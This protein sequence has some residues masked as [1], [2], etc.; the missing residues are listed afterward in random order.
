MKKTEMYRQG[1]VLVIATDKN[2][3]GENIP[4][5]GERVVLAHGEVTGHAHAIEN[6]GCNLYIDD[7][8]RISDTDSMNMIARLGGGLIPDRLLVCEKEVE[9][10]H[11]EH[12][13]IHL[14]S[15]NYIVRIQREYS[16]TEL[17]NVAD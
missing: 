10:K 1:D 9:L 15:G 6:S 12:S 7:S 16:P 11:E 14:K 2:T 17:R 3:I 5:E 13:T 8:T 4:R